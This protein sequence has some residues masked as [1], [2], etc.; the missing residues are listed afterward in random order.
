MCDEPEV[1]VL[2]ERARAGDQQAWNHIVERFAPL[3]WSACVRFR[4]TAADA[5]D[6]AASVWLR[7]V[8]RLGTIRE[9]AALPG[10]LATTARNECLQLLKARKRQDPTD[11][12]AL[13]DSAVAASDE[14]LLREERHIALRDAFGALPQRCKTLLSQLFA[15]P[16]ARYAEISA[17]L[18]LPVGS[19][20]PTRLRCLSI[21]RL[22]PRLRALDD[23]PDER[24]ESAK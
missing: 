17:Q 18:R 20:G 10:W 2:I 4:L 8:E 14:W 19:I 5:E 22:H 16:P 7:L 1:V 3:V 13:P 12:E 24:G 23:D 15:D 9:P 11:S 21:L 6:I